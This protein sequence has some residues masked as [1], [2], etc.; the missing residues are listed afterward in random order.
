MEIRRLDHAQYRG[1]EYHASYF[2]DGYY[3]IEFLGDRFSF[4][5][6]KFSQPRKYDLRDTILSGCRLLPARLSLSRDRDNV[7]VDVVSGNGIGA[8]R[9]DADLS[10]RA[11]VNLI[12][13]SLAIDPQVFSL[14]RIFPQQIDV[15]L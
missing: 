13:V 1:R 7:P 12:A 9:R 14:K 11:E 10:L 2:T 5:Y 3:E 4:S 6:Q 15:F 8:V